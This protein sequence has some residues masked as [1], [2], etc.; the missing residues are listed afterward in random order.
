MGGS[1]SE[2]P[3]DPRDDPPPAYR[4]RHPSRY[5]DPALSDEG[6]GVGGRA[7]AHSAPEQ[8]EDM[9]KRGGAMP[10]RFPI[11]RRTRQFPSITLAQLR[12]NLQSGALWANLQ[13][14][15]LW[16]NLQSG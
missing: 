2:T 12:C 8:R 3:A 1:Q 7:D 16:A 6:R 13:S 4:A 10:P 5:F 15:A 9:R 11:Q 14:G